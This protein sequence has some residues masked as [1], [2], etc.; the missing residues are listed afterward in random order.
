MAFYSNFWPHQSGHRGHFIRELVKSCDQR[1]NFFNNRVAST[2]NNSPNEVT[3]ATSVN[4]FKNTLDVYLNSKR[5]K[6]SQAVIS[7]WRILRGLSFCCNLITTFY[8]QFLHLNK[9][10]MY[11]DPEKSINK[12][13]FKLIFS[14]KFKLI[15]FPS[16][17]LYF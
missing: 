12:L 14:C 6:Q 11:S 17:S 13:I 9:K 8:M 16:I 15:C 3:V 10:S 1:H 7:C 2:Q 4:R 5:P